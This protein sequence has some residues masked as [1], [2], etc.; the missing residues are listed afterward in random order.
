MFIAFTN[1]PDST[2]YQTNI[3]RLPSS[4]A[5]VD[6]TAGGV[7]YYLDSNATATD[8]TTSISAVTYGPTTSSTTDTSATYLGGAITPSASTTT[9]A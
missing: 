4:G 5:G 2:Y 1:R 3:W 6:R 8:I 7:R 9:F